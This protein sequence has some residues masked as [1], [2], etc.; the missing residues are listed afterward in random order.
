MNNVLQRY[1]EAKVCYSKYNIDLESCLKKLKKIRISINCWQGD[2]IRG[3]ENNGNNLSGGIDVTGNYPGVPRNPEE[4]RSDLEVALKQIPGNH[5][6]NLHA[7]YAESNGEKI[8]RN[9]I[10]PELFDNW[11]NWAKSNN[12]G[13]DFNPTLFSHPLADN[14]TLSSIDNSIRDFWI[15]HC[16]SCRKIG[17]YIGK[18]LNDQCLTN[19]WIPDGSKDIPADRLGPRKRLKKS[20]DEIFSINLNP[21]YI[22]DSVESKLFGIGLESYTVG[23]HEFYMNYTNGKSVLYLLDAGHFH[24]TEYISDKISSM[25]LFKD[26]LALHV[27]RPVRWDSDHVII[28]NDELNEISKEIVRNNAIDKVLI[29]LDFFDASI[30]RVAALVIGTRNMLKSLLLA[31]LMPNDYLVEL[32]EKK[33]F[34]SRLAIMEELKTFPFGDVWNYYC[35]ISNVPLESEWLN[36]IKKYEE[37]VFLKRK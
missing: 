5:K 30:N 17:E 36:I 37:D 7:I 12:L 8:E 35:H 3:F 4:L 34:T 28:L 10:V 14:G 21:K 16:I 13:L 32:E 24:P 25:L 22:I 33:D 15:E 11:I 29:G 18:K 2:D 19:I 20:L 27:S 23:S 9:K 26:K 1:E 31:L 6:I